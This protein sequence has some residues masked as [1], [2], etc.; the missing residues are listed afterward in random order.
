MSL[1]LLHENCGN[2]AEMKS[3]SKKQ[4]LEQQNVVKMWQSGLRLR[5]R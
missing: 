4:E 1:P 2:K 3:A 5:E